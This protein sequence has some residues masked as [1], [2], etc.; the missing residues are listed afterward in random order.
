MTAGVSEV[1]YRLK[2]RRQNRGC[3][4][5]I[6]PSRHYIIIIG[7]YLFLLENSP[8]KIL[9][10]CGV[11]NGVIAKA[12]ELIIAQLVGILLTLQKVAKR[13]KAIGPVGTCATAN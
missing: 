4:E 3:A 5:N 12:G 9:P 7:R 6:V 10:A 2:F 8:V 1:E 13:A 11:R